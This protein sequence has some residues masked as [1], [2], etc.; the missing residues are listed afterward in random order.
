M[1]N[2]Q[3][4]NYSKKDFEIWKNTN[5]NSLYVKIE[6]NTII[7]KKLMSNYVERAESIK[8][9]INDVLKKY[10]INDV[11]LIINLSDIPFNNPYFVGF[12]ST[13]NININTIPNFSF[14]Q[15]D[16]PKSSNFF[17]I[18]E[19]ILNETIEWDNKQD[20]IMWSGL[21]S[22][23]IRER[24]NNFSKNNNL[25][26]FNLIDQYDVNKKFYTLPEHCKYKYLLDLEGNGY[27]GR[28]P[29]LA[30]TGSCVILLENI[31]HDRD[32]KLYYDLEFKEDIHYIKV[33]YHKEDSIESIHDKIINKIHNNDCKKIGLL[34]K[35]K[36][37]NIFTHDK[38][39]ESMS[40]ILKYY[41]EYYLNQDIELNKDL[42]YH[43]PMANNLKRIFN[44]YK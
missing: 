18:K 33:R 6:N 15:W 25:Y 32:Y 20:K 3:I 22:N 8:Q 7:Y 12:C 34:C 42:I 38:I 24:F 29:Y 27:S 21:N 26:E 10:T 14:Y 36:A 11:E 2:T 4:K 16:Y 41:S 37:M 39:I 17:E 1:I 19:D 40:N 43:I 13:T 9:M 44:K 23:I 35:E 5:I 28:F 31:D 30:L